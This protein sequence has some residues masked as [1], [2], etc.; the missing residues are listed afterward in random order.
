MHEKILRYKPK[1]AIKGTGFI[2][3]IITKL[4]LELHY[5]GHNFTGPGTN[6]VLRMEKNDKPVNKVDK[7]SLIHDI[8]YSEGFDK[9]LSDQYLIKRNEEILNNSESSVDEINQARIVNTI[10]KMKSVVGSGLN[11]DYIS[12]MDKFS[13]FIAEQNNIKKY[14]SDTKRYVDMLSEEDKK[15]LREMSKKYNFECNF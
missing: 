1:I 15:F 13:K 10:M 8:E 9:D 12:I 3:N 4:P 5:P 14:M 2:N 7:N 11:H 6:L